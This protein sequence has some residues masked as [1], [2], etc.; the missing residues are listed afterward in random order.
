VG[1]TDSRLGI[2]C[3]TAGAK[4]ESDL[5]WLDASWLADI[6]NDGREIVSLELS[7]GQGQNPAIYLRGTDGSPAVRLGYGSRP[8]L[9][10]DG[11][12]VA[13]VRKNRESSRIVLL[14]TGAGEEKPLSTGSIQPETAEWFSDGQRILFSGNEASQ[15]PRTYTY[16][17]ANGQI[18]PVTP[19]GVRA[20]A[21][22]PNSQSAIV[23]RD[24]KASLISLANGRE[25]GLG[26]V[27]PNISV[28][29]WSGDGEHLFLQ[30]TD[31]EHQSAALLRMDALSGHLEM[32]RD[33][34]LPDRTAFFYGTSRLSA[35]GKSYAFTFQRDLST[36]YL[37]NGIKQ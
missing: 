1:N 7:S 5:G 11:K 29:R 4:E 35:D 9:S 33:L 28:I 26:A 6:S 16:D 10:P 3:F 27:G 8:T 15:A 12:W 17:L 19:P 21:V 2:R 14:P 31:P 37:V 13:C 36:L 30:R 23:L 32:W 22:S 18:H 25:T 20:S 24:G 34:K